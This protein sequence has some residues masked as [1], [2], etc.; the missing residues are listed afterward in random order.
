MNGG[1]FLQASH[2]S[3]AEHGSFSSPEWQVGVL[4]SIVEPSAS[5]LL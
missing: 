2:L 4:R 3:E 5:C 1:E